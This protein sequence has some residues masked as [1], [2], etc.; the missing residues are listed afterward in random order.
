[1][2]S[3]GGETFGGDVEGIFEGGLVGVEG[4]AVDGVDDGGHV[5]IPR[6]GASDDA[7]FGG[8]GVD[9]IGLEFADKIAGGAVALVIDGGVDLANHGIDLVEF[10]VGVLCAVVE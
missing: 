6:R 9:D 3:L 1:M 5:E 8:V 10:D 4:E 7:G 2:A